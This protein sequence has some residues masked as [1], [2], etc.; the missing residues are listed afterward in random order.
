MNDLR[1][2]LRGLVPFALTFA[3]V[4]WIWWEHNVFFRRYGLQDAWTAFLNCVLLFVV[5]FYVYPLRF[6]TT[7][8]FGGRAR[9]L[10]DADWQLVM[11]TYSSGVLLVF[12][13]FILMHW[14]AWRQRAELQLDESE[15]LTLKFSTRAH[16]SSVA[17]ALVSLLLVFVLPDQPAWAG[18]VYFFMGPLHAWNGYKAGAAQSKL[19]ASGA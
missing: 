11:L 15:R 10:A 2:L 1:A 8:L 9:E 6:L 12:V 5:L 14:R 13:V 4:C 19:K 18:M 3:M 7:L 16:A 17:V